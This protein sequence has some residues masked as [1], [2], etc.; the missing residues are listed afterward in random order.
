[1]GEIVIVVEWSRE[2]Y[3]GKYSVRGGYIFWNY[4]KK[5]I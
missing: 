5:V 2:R 4:I 1:M 3:G